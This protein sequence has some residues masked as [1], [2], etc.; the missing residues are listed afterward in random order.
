MP[1][2][3]SPS[4]SSPNIM[5]PHKIKQPCKSINHASRRHVQ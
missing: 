1:S 2:P 3:M 4:M 5:T